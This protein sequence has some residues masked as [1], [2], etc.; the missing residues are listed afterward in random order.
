MIYDFLKR[1]GKKLVHSKISNRIFGERRKKLFFR[2]FR[3]NP[4]KQITLSM[5]C[6]SLFTGGYEGRSIPANLFSTRYVSE[7]ESGKEINSAVKSIAFYLTQFHPFEENNKWWGKG[8]TEWTNVTQS[9]P[10][11]PGH[12][13]PQLPIDVGFYD[14]RVPE[15]LSRQIELAK[16]Y[17]IFGFCFYYYWFSGK[18]LMEKPLFQYLQNK[19]FDFPFCLCWANESWRRN[20]WHNGS[21]I[22][23]EQKINDDDDEKF[24]DDI[25]DFLLDER[26]IRVN[27][28]P[29][30]LIYRPSF[31]NKDRVKILCTRLRK[32]A[33]EKYGIQSLYLV[34]A[35]T[36]DFINEN[37]LEWG[38]DAGVEF[39][40]HGL[41][42]V[43]K[44]YPDYS[45]HKEFRGKF[46]GKIYDINEYLSQPGTFAKRKYTLFKT[47]FPGWDNT[48]R[49]GASGKIYLSGEISYMTWLRKSIEFI[50]NNNSKDENFV[51]IFA[52]NE[53]AEGAHLEPD[54][55]NGYAM[56]EATRSVL[57]EFSEQAVSSNKII[58]EKFT[59]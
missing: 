54:S 16:E 31:W 27:G 30:V 26:Y 58:V 21:E 45:F 17:G 1:I 55:E 47:V 22:L 46:L 53:W 14:L 51:F 57:S 37:P 15:V 56:L 29:M 6:R 59:P 48:P 38:F 50:L 9:K 10:L 49:N 28:S 40:A 4:E 25:K 32:Y 12:H 3:N 13:Q 33:K 43:P 52:W 24:I 18:R 5:A 23:M 20:W 8:F 44:E 34:A 42:C 41:N 39:P 19:K 7:R 35:L 2:Y 11:F 36:Y